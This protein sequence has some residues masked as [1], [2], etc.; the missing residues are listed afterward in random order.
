MIGLIGTNT[1]PLNNTA[2]SN[3]ARR[4]GCSVTI[5]IFIVYLAVVVLV[6]LLLTYYLIYQ[7]RQ[8]VALLKNFKIPQLQL[9]LVLVLV[10]NLIIKY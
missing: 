9:V 10:L 6:E 5:P 1:F 4:A 2:V 7:V 3:I 8:N